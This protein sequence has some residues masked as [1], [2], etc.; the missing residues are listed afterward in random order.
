MGFIILRIFGNS[1]PPILPF[2]EAINEALEAIND[3]DVIYIGEPKLLKN[4]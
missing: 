1:L 2:V 3:G 4:L